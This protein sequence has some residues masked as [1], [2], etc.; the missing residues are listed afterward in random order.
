[1]TKHSR[2]NPRPGR[3][4]VVNQ[5]VHRLKSSRD[6]PVYGRLHTLAPGRMNFPLSY[7]AEASRP[8]VL[9]SRASNPRKVQETAPKVSY[10]E[11]LEKVFMFKVSH[12]DI[13]SHDSFRVEYNA[14]S[15]SIYDVNPS[16]NF[17]PSRLLMLTSP[18]K[19]F[20]V[21]RFVFA[22]HELINRELGLISG[23]LEQAAHVVDDI[24]PL[25]GI[26]PQW[27]RSDAIEDPSYTFRTRKFPAS[28]RS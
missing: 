10:V 13:P 23:R 24:E 26:T 16:L 4:R 19:S 6:L 25:L 22:K 5:P 15:K 8:L 27:Q 20:S 12:F 28:L 2:M 1:M 7:K 21:N 17:A 14:V 18:G 9:F 11:A 3:R